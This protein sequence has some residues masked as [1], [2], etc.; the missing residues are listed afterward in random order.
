MCEFQSDKKSFDLISKSWLEINLIDMK[1]TISCKSLQNQCK[2]EGSYHV[3]I[4]F[5]D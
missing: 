1:V 2:S 3:S 4:D 5:L